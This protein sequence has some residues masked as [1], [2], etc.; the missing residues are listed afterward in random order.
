MNS[1]PVVGQRDVLKAQFTLITP[2]GAEQVVSIDTWPATVGKASQCALPLSGWRAAKEHARLTQHQDGVWLEDLGSMAGT[3]VN[4]ERVVRHGPLHF[5]DEI[6]IAGYRI[7]MTEQSPQE[8]PALQAQQPAR[9]NAARG[10]EVSRTSQGNDLESS[11]HALAS[12]S[13]VGSA[14]SVAAA[15]LPLANQIQAVAAAPSQQDADMYEWRQRIHK[16]LLETIDLR[17]R[18]LVRMSDTDLRI[19]SEALIKELVGKQAPSIPKSVDH[20]QLTQAVLHEAVGLGPLE[21][22]LADQSITEIMVNRYNEVFVERAGRLVRH[23]VSFTSDRAVMGIIERIV[24]PL[25][26]RIDESSPMVDARLKDG[27]RVNAI[28]P[29][30]ALKG[31][32]ITIRKFSVKKLQPG[33]LVKYASVSEPMIE[34]LRTCVEHRKNIVVSGGTGSGKTTFLNML[35]NF[36]PNGERIVT[37]EDAAELQLNHSHLISLESRP[38]NAE[39]RG[40]VAI[41]DLVRNCLR[42]RPDRIV[43]GECRGGEALDMLQAMNTGHEGSMTT[44]HAN[45]PRDAVA[46]METMILM[47]GMDLPLAAVREQIASAVDILVQQTRFPCGTRKVTSITEVCGMENGRIQLMEL[48]RFDRTGRDAEGRIKGSFKPCGNIPTFFE[49]LREQ[50]ATLNI[51]GFTEGMA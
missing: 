33:D 8:S 19:E 1:A 30:L 18:D 49:E 14:G 6:L 27:S 39:G 51:T 20:A 43:V 34:F 35:S 25:G 5:G 21:D 24:S 11:G 4:G 22:L 29:P 2:E 31:P 44:L 32:T 28:I 37:V 17:R 26:R 13:R 23:G 7:R 45:T 3:T 48:F 38:S 50:G 42:M 12:H 36:I 10:V 41:R 40:A 47:A 16:L 46:R 9:P 15:Q